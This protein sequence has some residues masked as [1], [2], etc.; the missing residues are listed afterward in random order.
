MGKKG[1]DWSIF[2]EKLKQIKV[3]SI[4]VFIFF[5]LIIQKWLYKSKKLKNIIIHGIWCLRTYLKIVTNLMCKC[6]ENSTKSWSNIRK[7]VN[8]NNLFSYIPVFNQRELLK[9][10]TLQTSY[11]SLVF[12]WGNTGEILTQGTLKNK[13]GTNSF[14]YLFQILAEQELLQ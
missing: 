13:F 9:I 2:L 8:K 10:F 11:N 4:F 12:R 14:P 3:F 7:L 5:R 6:L 1:H